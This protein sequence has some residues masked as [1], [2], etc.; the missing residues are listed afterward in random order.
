MAI[1][2]HTRIKNNE[3]DNILQVVIIAGNPGVFQVYPYPYPPKPVPPP[4]VRVLTG[5]DP[6]F[7]GFGRSNGLTGTRPP[8]IINDT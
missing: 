4:R 7:E 6:G 3:G 1:V 2:N 8:A 5:R